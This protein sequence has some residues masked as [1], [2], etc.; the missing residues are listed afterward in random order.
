MITTHAIRVQYTRVVYRFDRFERKTEVD[1][2]VRRTTSVVR[3]F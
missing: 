2:F 3:L 1:L